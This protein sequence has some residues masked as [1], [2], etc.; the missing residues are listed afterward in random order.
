[1]RVLDLACLEGHFAIEFALH[2]AEVIGIEARQVSLQKAEF[3]KDLLSLHKLT[4]IRDDVR[5]F[6]RQ[7]YGEFDVILCCG[8][9][10]H[11]D[12]PDAMHLIN[13][14]FECCSRVAVLNTHFSLTGSESYC[15][16]GTSYWGHFSQEHDATDTED[17]Q[18][19]KLWS[20]IKNVRSFV[21]TRPSLFNLLRHVGFTSVYE[22]IN[23]YVYTHPDS[24]A[25]PVSPGHDRH[26]VW[27]DRATFVAIKGSRQKVISSLVADELPEINR[28]EKPPYIRPSAAGLGRK[29]IAH[30]PAPSRKVLS[31]LYHSVARRSRK[32]LSPPT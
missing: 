2:G 29:L 28:P 19:A 15:W 24:T 3:I 26:G 12:A 4:L 20:S 22:C 1:M 25:L 30:L 11:M 8:I 31:L 5:N 16:N 32:S 10:Y 9:L 18:L 6:T 21:L 23:P 17:E 13:N 14:I 27:E 7:Q